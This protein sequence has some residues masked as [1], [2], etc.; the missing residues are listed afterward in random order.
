MS[1]HLEMWTRLANLES[2]ANF[3]DSVTQNHLSKVNRTRL[4][5]NC[6]VLKMWS[7]D[8]KSALYSL[9]FVINFLW[10]SGP[11]FSCWIQIT[12]TKK[13]Y[14]YEYE[15][16]NS[17]S[18]SFAAQYDPLPPSPPSIPLLPQVGNQTTYNTQ[19]KTKTSPSCCYFDKTT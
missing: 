13:K 3:S 1:W 7:P 6:L 17:R 10:L 2:L 12:T 18:S 19:I 9:H 16:S 4:C 5:N 14:E 11:L 15:R 8:S